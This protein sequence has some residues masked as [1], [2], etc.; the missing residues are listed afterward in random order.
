MKQIK[1]KQT[2]FFRNYLYETIHIGNSTRATGRTVSKNKYIFN[3]IT[4]HSFNTGKT[5][6]DSK[7]GNNTKYNIYSYIY[8][9]LNLYMYVPWNKSVRSTQLKM[10]NTNSIIMN[11]NPCYIESP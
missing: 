7:I 4:R 2:S 5:N 10:L 1:R 11:L 3:I 9:I 8:T 6:I